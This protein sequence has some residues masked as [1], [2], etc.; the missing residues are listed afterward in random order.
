MSKTYRRE[1]RGEGRKPKEVSRKS[2]RNSV[3]TELQQLK[4]R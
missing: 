3:H 1:N 4:R 2:K